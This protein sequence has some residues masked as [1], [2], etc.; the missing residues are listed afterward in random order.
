MISSCCSVVT[1]LFTLINTII[2]P[3]EFLHK[4]PLFF[5][6]SS[7]IEEEKVK[8]LETVYQYSNLEYTC[9]HWGSLSVFFVKVPQKNDFQSITEEPKYQAKA[10][11]VVT[12]TIKKTE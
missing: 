8:I 4:F 6:S 12:D 9:R 5:F 10:L 2:N 11:T 7:P 1:V 3:Y